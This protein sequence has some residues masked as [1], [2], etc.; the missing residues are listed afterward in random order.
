MK[1]LGYLRNKKTTTKLYVDSLANPNVIFYG[2][3]FMENLELVFPSSMS[4]NDMND[5]AKENFFTGHIQL[6]QIRF[7][8]EDFEGAASGGYLSIKDVDTQALYRVYNDDITHL[9]QSMYNGQSEYLSIK[10]NI[11]EGIFAVKPSAQT[12]SFR[13]LNS[14]ELNFLETEW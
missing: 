14:G 12:I 4:D 3:Y 6:F 2:K 10:D 9:I 8:V 11:L 5:K 1:H 13:L 7:V